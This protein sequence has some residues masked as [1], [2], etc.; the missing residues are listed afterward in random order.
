[1]ATLALAR[2]SP[3]STTTSGNAMRQP[4]HY[5]PSS[6]NGFNTGRQHK[7]VSNGTPGKLRSP[8]KQQQQQRGE[9]GDDDSET[10]VDHQQMP[11]RRVAQRNEGKNVAVEQDGKSTE[12]DHDNHDGEDDD[13]KM[14]GTSAAGAAKLFMAKLG[15]SSGAAKHLDIAAL[16]KE[17][18]VFLPPKMP[19]DGMQKIPYEPLPTGPLTANGTTTNGEASSPKQDTARTQDGSNSSNKGK[20]AESASAQSNGAVPLQFNWPQNYPV[21]PGYHNLGNTC[22][23]NST[24][25]ALTHTAPLVACL[26]SETHHSPAYCRVAANKKFCLL[27]AMQRHIHTCFKNGRS[28][29]AV[30]PSGIVNKLQFIAKSMRVGR[31]EDAHEFLRFSLDAMQQSAMINLKKAPAPINIKTLTEAERHSTL[32][33]RIFGGK[34]RSRVTCLSCG[35]N[36]DTFDSFM[37]LSLDVAKAY[38]IKDSLRDFV[39]IDELKGS[40]K[41]KCEK[42]KKL[43]N[44]RKQF[45]INQAPQILHIHL[46]RFTPTGKKISGHIT[47]PEMLQLRDYMS[48]DVADRNPTYRLYAVVCHSGSGPHSGHYFAHVRSGAGRWHCMNDSSVSD[49]DVKAALQ[50][51]NAYL[52]FYERTNRLGDVVGKI[53]LPATA[54]QQATLRTNANGELAHANRPTELGKRKER[55]DDEDEDG[56]HRDAGALPFASQKLKLNGAS[57]PSSTKGSP[58]F[59]N[60]QR[61][62][63]LPPGQHRPHSPA[64]SSPNRGRPPFA[65]NGN[66]RVGSYPGGSVKATKFYNS[67]GQGNR[68]KVVDLMKGK[69]R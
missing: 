40:N 8:L 27:C 56:G 58:Q 63:A 54:P 28:Y 16:L 25:Q 44:A 43:V 5:K 31:Q 12:A 45:T 18:L 41:Y 64:S 62:S 30:Q 36:S 66:G 42:C 3:G 10:E 39:K 53:K 35:H 29:G 46:K 61:S 17:P 52:L 14:E 48:D 23:L 55:D 33:H 24:L 1:M 50:Q 22:F 67:K 15:N 51:R 26:M 6:P 37:D 49:T 69:P 60:H 32:I 9:T 7:Q 38:D 21:G 2:P 47:Y 57:S 65:P 19:D 4:N 34:L 68:P 20:S 11:P 59:G 13:D